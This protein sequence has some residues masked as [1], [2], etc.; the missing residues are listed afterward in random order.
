MSNFIFLA[1]LSTFVWTTFGTFV[2]DGLETTTEPRRSARIAE[3]RKSTVLFLINYDGDYD[4]QDD[5]I[6]IDEDMFNSDMHLLDTLN[7]K[8]DG[9][10]EE[11]ENQP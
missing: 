3:N 6:N 7:T 1:V 2:S 4:L 11:D 5:R 10:I 9:D 8:Y